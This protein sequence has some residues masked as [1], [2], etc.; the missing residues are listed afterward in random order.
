MLTAA[1]VGWFLSA[2]AFAEDANPFLVLNLNSHSS[3]VQAVDFA[4]QADALCTAGLDKVVRVW[5]VEMNAPV[6]APRRTLRWAVEHG[7]RGSIYALAAD[8]AAARIAVGGFGHLGQAGEIALLDLQTGELLDLEIGGHRQPVAALDFTS[9]GSHLVSADVTGRI[10]WREME[11][12]GGALPREIAPPLDGVVGIPVSAS[13]NN[14]LVYP[15]LRQAAAGT[16]PARWGVA[17]L[18]PGEMAQP[19]VFPET[20]QGQVTAVAADRQGARIAAADSTGKIRFWDLRPNR[21]SRQVQ[22]DA[23]ALSLE[24]TADG[25]QL[26]VG[27]HFTAESGGTVARLEVRDFNT[28]ARNGA[29]V[30]VALPVTTCAI[31]RDASTVAFAQGK[32]VHLVNLGNRSVRQQLGGA[33]EV[34]GARIQQVGDDYEVWYLRQD[35]VGNAD[36]RVW[37]RRQTAEGAPD[38][39]VR[40]LRPDELGGAS[41]EDALPPPVDDRFPDWQATILE[42]GQGVRLLGPGVRRDIVYDRTR[43]GIPRVTTWIP[44]PQDAAPEALAVGS[45]GSDFSIIV[46]QARTGRVLRAF[47]GHQGAVTSL[48]AS[49]DGHYLVS[50]S[51]DGTVRLWDVSDLSTPDPVE[52]R[53]G[54]RLVSANGALQVSSLRQP[55]PLYEKGLRVGDVIRRIRWAD[56]GTN[57]SAETPDAIYRQLAELPW[58]VQVGFE[59]ERAGEQRDPF[60]LHGWHEFLALMD[61]DPD[62]IVW[63]PA[64]YYTCSAAGER[65]IGWQ[66][67]G[68]LGETPGFYEAVQFH[69]TL[70]RPDL[71]GRL[72][73]AGSLLLAAADA[74]GVEPPPPPPA[75]QVAPRARPLV[76][77]RVEPAPVIPNAAERRVADVLPPTVRLIAPAGDVHVTDVP[78]VTITAEAIA[79]G[80]DPITQVRL[81]IGGSPPPEHKRLVDGG[82]STNQT[83]TLRLEPGVHEIEILAETE[84]SYGTSRKLQVEYQPSNERRSLYV[85]A[86]GIADYNGPAQ[87]DWTAQDARRFGNVVRQHSSYDSVEVNL[88]CNADATMAGIQQGLSWL[89][90]SMTQR[91]VGVIFFSGHGVRHEGKFYLA[92]VEGDP[93][94]IPETCFSEDLLRNFFAQMGGRGDLVLM[95]DACYSGAMQLQSL[96]TELARDDYNVVVMVSSRDDQRSW[97]HAQ[98]QAGAFSKA[99][100]EGLAGQADAGT[101]FANDVVEFDELFVYVHRRVQQLVRAIGEQQEPLLNVRFTAPFELTR[102]QQQTR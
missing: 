102:V 14:G 55:G 95:L 45:V 81:L 80:D 27:T 21:P 3:G 4:G 72:P 11:E 87:L 92:P 34:T 24:F 36:V 42:S 59:T 78:E 64:G 83:W 73:S 50:T 89:A 101:R 38:T 93:E 39:D 47:R 15:V 77:T 20:L 76:V 85:L 49:V 35:S 10:L 94:R 65:L 22:T 25:E 100:V 68:E 51:V 23:V 26:V 53:W 99:L 63:T 8:P 9:D 31:S 66:V 43:E 40:R 84:Q 57:R 97:E 6:R 67:N 28:G 17:I 71:I 13:G 1:A 18:R 96:A 19:Y 41:P 58:H 75:P 98:W 46:Y 82:K 88:V 7:Q 90:D 48:D 91:D 70:Y 37:Y 29:P 5:N 62:W 86:I 79:R 44:D 54:A 56:G 2:T 30:P 61:V 60:Q 74:A 69:K 12:D 16:S 33:A 32:A 52:Q